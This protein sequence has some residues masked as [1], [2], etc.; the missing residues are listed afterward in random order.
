MAGPQDRP[1]QTTASRAGEL[2][3]A[4]AA[5]Y[6]EVLLV[7]NNR[8]IPYAVAGAFALR[9]HTGIWRLT[10]DLDVFVPCTDFPGMLQELHTAGYPCEIYDNVWLAKVRSGDAFVDFIAG[11][12][13]AVIRVSA[14]WITRAQPAVVVGVPSRILAP[15]EL[16]ASK[17]FVARRERFDGADIAHLVFATRGE[18][19][20][21]RILN[22]IGDHWEMLLWALVLF[23]YA[24]PAQSNYVPLSIW[25]HL[26]ARF[27]QQVENRDPQARFRGSLIDDNMFAVDVEEWGLDDLLSEYRARCAPKLDERVA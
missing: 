23:R 16:L 22:L 21:Q 10:K 5:F 24:Y 20:W 18:L 27:L 19:D 7:L 9:Q 3:A 26:T 17:L 14:D 2:I 25:R 6:R 1:G 12:S 8:H 13:N 15:E 4:Q 11:M